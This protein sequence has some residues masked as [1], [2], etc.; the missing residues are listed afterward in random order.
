MDTMEKRKHP[1][2]N[3]RIPVHYRRITS[4]NMEFK[5]SLMQN[6]SK[7]GARITS[8]EFLPLNS[9]LLMKLPLESG[10]K[11]VEG[12]SQVVWVKKMG[13]GEQYA[14]GLEFVYLN[15]GDSSQIADF[16]FRNSQPSGDR[17]N[18]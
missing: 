4:D 10:R 18:L 11:S 12:V 16:V 3:S 2:R 17:V 7:S 8:Y 6:I 9:R 14:I 1:R 5:G 13:F 15:Q